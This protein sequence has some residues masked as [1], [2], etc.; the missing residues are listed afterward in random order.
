MGGSGRAV[1][2]GLPRGPRGPLGAHGPVGL[3]VPRLRPHGRALRRP[4]RRRR[5]VR[6]PA[7]LLH[8]PRGRQRRRP[9]AVGGLR[10][11]SAVRRRTGRGPLDAGLRRH[12][13]P[14]PPGRH[15]PDPRPELGGPERLRPPGGPQQHGQRRRRLPGPVPPPVRGVLPSGSR[16]R[17]QRPVAHSHGA[18]AHRLGRLQHRSGRVHGRAARAPA[19]R[20][21]EVAAR[22]P[23]GVPQPDPR[24]RHRLPGAVGRRRAGRSGVPGADSAAPAQHLPALGGPPGRPLGPLPPAHRGLRGA[25]VGIQAPCGGRHR[26]RAQAD[27]GATTD[28]PPRVLADERSDPPRRRPRR[29]RPVGSAHRR[30]APPPPPAP[31]GLRPAARRRG[32][33]HQRPAQAPVRGPGL[34]HLAGLAGALARSGDARREDH[35]GPPRR[36]GAPRERMVVEEASGRP[37]P[38]RG[39]TPITTRPGA[40][41]SANSPSRC[42]GRD[43]RHDEPART[44]LALRQ[45]L[46][47]T[48]RRRRCAAAR[49][50]RMEGLPA[51]SGPL[52]LPALPWTPPVTTCG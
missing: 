30:A 45:G 27:G 14:A 38:A 34:A 52:A 26:A 18:G 29:G 11:E 20:R 19:A 16:G 12:R 6:L 39:S 44:R 49:R 43:R 23:P 48:G 9:R 5:P 1:G 13:R 47:R 37:S 25:D 31:T 42:A 28:H 17:D 4:L 50:A 3:P 46:L 8:G 2:A 32:R 24:P 15:A 51:R 10:Q 36:G 22:R 21:T 41:E 7:V 35:G 33:N 40:P